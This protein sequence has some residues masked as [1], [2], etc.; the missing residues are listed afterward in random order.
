[1]DNLGG[2]RLLDSEVNTL[3]AGAWFELD[4]DDVQEC[5]VR[6]GQWQVAVDEHVAVCWCGDVEQLDCSALTVE[7]GAG[8][9]HDGNA[10]LAAEDQRIGVGAAMVNQRQTETR[11]AFRWL[12]TVERDRADVTIVFVFDLTGCEATLSEQQSAELGAA[13]GEL[14]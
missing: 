13:L 6:S 4:L 10:G 11:G 9:P 1:M 14:R 7:R 5:L 3:V 2:Y 12:E 8:D